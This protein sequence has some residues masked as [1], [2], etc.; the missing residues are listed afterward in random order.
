MSVENPIQRDSNIGLENA[1]SNTEPQYDIIH[2]KD[3]TG[4]KTTVF[5][6]N[7]PLLS[8]SKILF[9]YVFRSPA[10][11]VYVWI[12][13]SAIIVQLSIFKYYYPYASFINGDSYSYLDTAYHNFSINIYPIGYSMFLRLLS[14]FTRSDIALVIVQYILI[15]TSILAFLFTLF[16][17]YNPEKLTKLIL[18]CFM[19]FNPIFLYLANYVSSDAFFLSLSLIWFTQLLWIVNNPT[20]K[21]IVINAITLFITFT[22]RYNALFYP[23]IAL[24]ALYKGGGSKVLKIGGIL[25]GFL[26]IGIFMLYT[27][28]KYYKLTGHWQFTPFTGWQTANN[29]LYAYRYVDSSKRKE[30]PKRFQEVD[31]IVRTYFD[32]TRDLKKHPQEQLIASTVY[33]WAPDSPLSI[34]MENQFKK[35]TIVGMVKK[36]AT[37]APLLEDYGKLLIKEYPKE[38]LKFYLIPNTL[39]YYAPPVEFLGQYSTGID[40]VSYI[41]QVWFDYKGNKLKTRF[42]DYKVN[43]LNF[44][45]VLI[46]TMNIVLL[47][48]LISFLILKGHKHHPRLNHGMLLIITLWI[49]NF[50]FSVLASPIALRFQ[51]F[52]ILVSFSFAVFLLEFLIKSAI[53]LDV[54]KV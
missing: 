22:V 49:V 48:T 15:Q 24:V 25:L 52:P 23:I 5:N 4:K 39:K 26:L 16:Y 27:G 20:K 31:N 41:A 1:G 21:I 53:G 12:A 44:F 9:N 42:K 40:S 10:N 13:L 32:T 14:I 28:N 43:T 30:L 37:V 46:G 34:Y 33:M 54:Y 2:K 6:P 19:L 38:Y 7:E 45:P 35:D 29:A 50:L 8:P 18:F 47:F 17:F 51:L 3:N 36:W 11:K